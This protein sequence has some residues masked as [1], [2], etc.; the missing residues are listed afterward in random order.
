MSKIEKNGVAFWGLE[1]NNDI[2]V[3][4]NG[5]IHFVIRAN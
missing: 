3:N 2:Y 5:E 4:F 1:Q